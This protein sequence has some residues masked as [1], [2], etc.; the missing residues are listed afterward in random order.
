MKKQKPLFK[1]LAEIEKQ[2]KLVALKA[3]VLG[4]NSKECMNCKK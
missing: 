4:H 1:E 2:G 3:Y